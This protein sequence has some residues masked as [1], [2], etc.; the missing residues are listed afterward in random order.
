M[1]PFL[2]I[3]S[4]LFSPSIQSLHSPPNTIPLLNLRSRFPE[5]TTCIRKQLESQFPSEL[6]VI[7]DW[8]N[9]ILRFGGVWSRVW[10]RTFCN[11][12][13]YEWVFWILKRA[14][15]VGLGGPP[16]GRMRLRRWRPGFFRS[17]RRFP[18]SSASSTPSVP[19]RTRRSS[20]K[21]C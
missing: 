7:A 20:V 11:S 8:I 15:E 18:P 3:S 13:D 1:H 5:F 12:V 21:S 19:P 10:G 4:K 16:G 2:L 9:W 17:T 14:G 6:C